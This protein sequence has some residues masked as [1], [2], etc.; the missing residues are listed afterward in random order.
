MK[1][2]PRLKIPLSVPLFVLAAV[3]L[4][5]NLPALQKPAATEVPHPAATAPDLQAALDAERVD[6]RPQV[7]AYL[8]RPDTFDIS[9]VEVEGGRVRLESWRYFQYGT[10][11][12]FVDGEAVLTAEIE[13][14]PDGTL[15]AAW[16]DPLTFGDGMSADEAIQTV[17]AAS[18]AGA[19]PQRFELAEGGEELAGGALLAGDQILIGLYEERVVYVET[20]ALMPEG[21]DQ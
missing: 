9:L 4:A 16:Y 6:D 10:R 3:A 8:G 17:A 7:L 1:R 21:G 20:L 5:C 12:D 11:I 18:P 19:A 13:P 15:F 2:A 14:M